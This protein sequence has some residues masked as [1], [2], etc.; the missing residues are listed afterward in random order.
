MSSAWIGLKNYKILDHSVLLN[1]IMVV[2][3]KESVAKPSMT[4][5]QNSLYS[6]LMEKRGW[7]FGLVIL[8]KLPLELFSGLNLSLL[9]LIMDLILLYLMSGIEKLIKLCLASS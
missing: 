8:V 1:Y 7:N 6:I 4:T 3:L 2:F 9:V 5:Q